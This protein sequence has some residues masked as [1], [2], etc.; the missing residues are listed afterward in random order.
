MKEKEKKKK[1]KEKVI[2]LLY[3][4][5]FQR[6]T[7]IDDDEGGEG[8]DKSN[9]KLGGSWITL[10]HGVAHPEHPAGAAFSPSYLGPGFFLQMR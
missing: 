5:Y 4:L 7:W 3:V 9:A 10:P 1:A 8:D 6:Q 2:D